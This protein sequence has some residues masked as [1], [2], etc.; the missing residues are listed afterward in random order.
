MHGRDRV[1]GG[2]GQAGH[3]RQAVRARG[4]VEGNGEPYEAT[5]EQYIVEEM[6]ASYTPGSRW[7]A[8]A[9]PDDR[10]KLLLYGQA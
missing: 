1:G 9:D 6:A 2:D 7:Q 8:K 4:E 3:E 10:T 5:V